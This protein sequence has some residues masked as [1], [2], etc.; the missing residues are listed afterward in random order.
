MESASN[1]AT[2]IGFVWGLPPSE[3]E[4]LLLPDVTGAPAG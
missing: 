4:L 1:N 3:P 2:K